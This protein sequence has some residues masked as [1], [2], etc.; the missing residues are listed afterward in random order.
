MKSPS[1][2]TP[3]PASKRCTHCREEKT[4]DAFYRKGKRLDSQCKA[5]ALLQKSKRRKLERRRMEKVEMLM[6]KFTIIEINK[7]DLP[8]FAGSVLRAIRHGV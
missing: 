3:K 1:D 2:S 6:N 4:L 7:P 5:C 8:T